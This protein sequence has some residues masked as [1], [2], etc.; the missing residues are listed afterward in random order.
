VIVEVV[1]RRSTLFR[2]H[3][4]ALEPLHFGR[5]T[6]HRF[7]APDGRFGVCYLA[8]SLETAIAET[9]LRNP[10]IR[11]L[12]RSQIDRRT[13]T[14]IEAAGELRLVDLVSMATL[15]RLGIDLRTVHGPYDACRALAARLHDD[16][17]GPDGLIWPSRFGADGRCIAVFD[18][19]AGKLRP[20]RTWSGKEWRD[21]VLDFLDRCGKSLAG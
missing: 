15:Q 17:S 1:P 16:P 10:E 20:G 9:L 14:E 18:R 19:A 5:E 2:V 6:C 21:R 11:T 4:V 12:P 13:L 3:R 7:D 8:L